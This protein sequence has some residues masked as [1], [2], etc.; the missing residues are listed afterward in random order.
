MATKTKSAATP[1]A[2]GADAAKPRSPKVGSP[3]AVAA[4]AAAPKA[5]PRTAPKSA[6]KAASKAG[7]KTGAKTAAAAAPSPSASAEPA[8]SAALSIR[9]AGFKFKDL[10]ERVVSATGTKKKDAKEIIEAVL[11]ELG[12]ALG[13]GDELNLPGLGRARVVKHAE[14]AGA[15]HLTLK[16]KR[17]PHKTRPADAKEPLAETDD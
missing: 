13:R 6:A 15:A 1:S 5:S 12:E 4:K 8:A 9:G 17:G 10:V 7:A 16:V 2:A 14:K 3:K 11:A